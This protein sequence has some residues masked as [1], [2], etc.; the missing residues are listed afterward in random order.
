MPKET[1]II[2][3]KAAIGPAHLGAGFFTDGGNKFDSLTD[4]V[5]WLSGVAHGMSGTEDP[6]SQINMIVEYGG[7]E[8]VV[9][10]LG[11]NVAAQ[12]LRVRIHMVGGSVAHFIAV[13]HD[14]ETDT[15]EFIQPTTPAALDL[16]ARLFSDGKWSIAV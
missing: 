15:N 9:T 6:L 16:L 2:E 7:G 11:Y 5:V 4:Q 14:E 10:D 1:E 8:Y 3:Q 13:Q 12:T